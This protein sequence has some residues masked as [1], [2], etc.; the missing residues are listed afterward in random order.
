MKRIFLAIADY[1]SEEIQNLIDLAVNIKK[2][3]FASG[4]IPL[5]QNKVLAM[6]FSKPSLRT[7]IRFR[8]GN[9]PT[10]RR[11]IIYFSG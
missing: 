8:Y 10:W 5:L 7:R 9:A 4:N 6:I 2:E 3:Y 1:S 11:C